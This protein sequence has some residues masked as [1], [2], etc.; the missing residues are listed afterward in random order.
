MVLEHAICHEAG[1]AIVA[2]NF[3]LSVQEIQLKQSIP[4]ACIDVAGATVRQACTV[5]AG[6]AAAEKLAFGSFDKA[7]DRDRLMILEIGGGKLEDHLDYATEILT[8]NAGCHREIWK[9]I[10]MNWLA[11]ESASI[12]SGSNF[13][14][15]NFE[16]MTGKRIKEIWQ[17][18]HPE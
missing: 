15:L 13:D 3:G 9:E 1:H 8:A 6:G 2:M 4:I 5:Y 17:R 14:K 11:E 18:Y 7:S 10:S 12:W 16:L